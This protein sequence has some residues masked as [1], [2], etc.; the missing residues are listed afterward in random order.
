MSSAVIED[1]ILHRITGS[2]LIK[3]KNCLG[4]T[5][6]EVSYHKL[7]VDQKLA[8]FSYT[9]KW[10]VTLYNMILPYSIIL[11]CKHS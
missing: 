1:K 4:R 11:L 7:V 9:A 8:E 3:V 2:S 6:S 5:D 10:I